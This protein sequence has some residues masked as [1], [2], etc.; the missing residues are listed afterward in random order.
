MVDIFNVIQVRSGQARFFESKSCFAALASSAM[1][2]GAISLS[3]STPSTFIFLLFRQINTTRSKRLQHTILANKTIWL[4]K[5]N[6]QIFVDFQ[7]VYSV[8][9]V[10][11]LTY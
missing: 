1:S 10:S 8:L 3:P 5:F 7:S 9:S 4:S 11:L 2:G 6:C